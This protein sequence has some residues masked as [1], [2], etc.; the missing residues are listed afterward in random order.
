MTTDAATSSP[1]DAGRGAGADAR[2][3]R[4]LEL[5]DRL[6]EDRGVPN[7]LGVTVLVQGVTYS[8]LL[9]AGRVWAATMAELLRGSA[10]ADA[11]MAALGVFY[12]DISR[13][14]EQVGGP[15]ESR[16]YLHL[17]NVTLGLPRDAQPTGLMLR[18]RAADV[19][20]WA[21]GTMGQLPPFAPRP[22]AD[23]PPTA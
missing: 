10:G 9:I 17:A 16:D 12:D 21:V 7:S 3:Q 8:G 4:L 19:S 14:Y 1:S 13:S 20:A 6:D 18:I 23:P 2:L 11:Q 15:D 5:W 22:A